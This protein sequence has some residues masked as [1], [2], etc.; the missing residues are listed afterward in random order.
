M[1]LVCSCSLA[2]FAFGCAQSGL[3]DVARIALPGSNLALV[4]TKDSSKKQHRCQLFDGDNAIS[5]AVM[6]TGYSEADLALQKIEAHDGD[7]SVYLHGGVYSV[8]VTV[9]VQHRRIRS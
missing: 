4:V 3:P 7:V 1:N 2:V 5:E 6:L 9:D 8:V